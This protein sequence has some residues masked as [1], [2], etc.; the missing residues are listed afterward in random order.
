MRRLPKE[1]FV[2]PLQNPVAG[3]K[4]VARDVTC[5]AFTM[6]EISHSFRAKVSTAGQDAVD[7]QLDQGVW[8]NSTEQ[9]D[10]R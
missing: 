6:R 7:V 2:P 1:G 4:S 9:L 3:N 10:H 8:L 5:T